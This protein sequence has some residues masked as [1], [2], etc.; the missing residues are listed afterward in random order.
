M[1]N[2]P[3]VPPRK[4]TVALVRWSKKPSENPVVKF[5]MFSVFGLI[6]CIVLMIFIRGLRSFGAV[7]L[8]TLFFAVLL[9][10]P[11]VRGRRTFMFGLTKRIN[12]TIAEIA[13]TPG[14]QLSV[15]EFQRLVK[16]GERRPLLVSGV[17][18]LNLHVERLVSLDN[19]APEK[20]LAVFT[21]DPPES[22]TES[23]DR[24]VAAAIDAGRGGAS[25]P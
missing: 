2:S 25:G 21:V 9:T 18:G 4:D 15:K 11:T 14:D 23:F 10:V 17:P 20:W 3:V 13:S 16:S 7:A 22:G 12:D 8:F 6:L 5:V 24:L 19:N 1:D